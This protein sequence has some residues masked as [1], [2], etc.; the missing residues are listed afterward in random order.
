MCVAKTAP[1]LSDTVEVIDG[2]LDPLERSESA[3]LVE[4]SHRITYEIALSRRPEALPAEIECPNYACKV[5]RTGIVGIREQR[6][7]L[8]RRAVELAVECANSPANRSSCRKQSTELDEEKVK[9][10]E[11]TDRLEKVLRDQC[12]YLDLRP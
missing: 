6:A 3:F 8:I 7:T 5:Q 11:E 10:S 1:D 12:G 2:K 4:P 9:L